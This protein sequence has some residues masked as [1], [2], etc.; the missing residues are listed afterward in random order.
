VSQNSGVH[1]DNYLR[2]S[3][4]R[5]FTDCAVMVTTPFEHF[6]QFASCHRTAVNGV[7][8]AISQHGRLD[9]K[10]NMRE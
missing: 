8:E 2:R 7:G 10:R 9:A 4:R 6:F 1:G 5:A 3:A